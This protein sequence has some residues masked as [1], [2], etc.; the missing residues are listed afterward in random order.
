[1][2]DSQQRF[3]VRLT[4]AQRKAVAEVAPELAGRLKLDERTQRTIPFTLAELKAIKEK[5]GRAIRHAGTG[6][7]R[8]SLRHVTDL[9]AQALD[10]SRGLG[11]SP[12]AS[13][14]TS[15]RS[16]CSTPSPRSGGA[17]R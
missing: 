13:G 6:M 5:A 3:P 11:A 14:S 4:Q 2:A 16:P 8:N 10:R 7:L 9:T 17:S 1:M 12:P 15:S